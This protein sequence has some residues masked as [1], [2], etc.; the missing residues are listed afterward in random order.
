MTTLLFSQTC[1]VCHQVQ[2]LCKGVDVKGREWHRTDFMIKDETGSLRVTMWGDN[3]PP[4]YYSISME[5]HGCS[6]DGESVG[7]IIRV[8]PLVANSGGVDRGLCLN[9]RDKQIVMQDK[10][11]TFDEVA[12]HQSTP[13]STN[14]HTTGCLV[15]LWSYPFSQF[16][17]LFYKNS[18]H[19]IKLIYDFRCLF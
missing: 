6:P 5:Q 9:V 14:S 1:L 3:I 2:V 15:L 12:D 18:N 17:R 16:N 10:V 11:F 7:L 8:R 13:K 4:I 19:I